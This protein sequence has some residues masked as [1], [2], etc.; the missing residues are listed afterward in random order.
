[1]PAAVRPLV[2]FLLACTAFAAL[3]NAAGAAWTKPGTCRVSTS[4][5]GRWDDLAATSSRFRTTK[6]PCYIA[7]YTVSDMIRDEKSG[8][9]RFRHSS[10]GARWEVRLS[11]RSR[12][13]KRSR[14]V[15][16]C[17]V[18]GGADAEGTRGTARKL[19]GGTIR[20]VTDRTG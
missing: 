7:A 6:V 20:W 14:R 13:A 2:P 8:R 5:A 4:Q 15:V 16:T 18:T 17:R 9:P 3:P 10:R 11:C 12:A 19:R 1:M